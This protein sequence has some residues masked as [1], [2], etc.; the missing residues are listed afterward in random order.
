MRMNYSKENRQLV[1]AV[2]GAASHLER[3]LSRDLSMVRGISLSEYLLL[4]SL[5][6]QPGSTTRVDLAADVGLT[7]S[8]VTRALRPL[9]KLGYVVT[10]KDPRDARRSLARLTEAGETLVKEA[11]KLIDEA[12]ARMG[13]LGE[14]RAADR[15]VV[16]RLLEGLARG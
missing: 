14:V 9:E 12:V 2:L 6:R 3:N 5:G 10:E 4:E 7:P 15:Q 16:V 11:S 8:G 13:A 1:F